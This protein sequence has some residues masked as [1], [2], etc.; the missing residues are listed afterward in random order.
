MGRGGVETLFWLGKAC[1]CVLWGVRTVGVPRAE[2]RLRAELGGVGK[3]FVFFPFAYLRVV[4]NERLAQ[5]HR[6]RKLH[7]S[8][9]LGVCQ[10]F[11]CVPSEMAK[12]RATVPLSPPSCCHFLP[13]GF[14]LALSVGMRTDVAVRLLAAKKSVT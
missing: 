6:V 11:M 12:G 4:Q 3:G 8:K 5:L 1:A 2:K 7:K 14:L 13:L 9:T 10:C